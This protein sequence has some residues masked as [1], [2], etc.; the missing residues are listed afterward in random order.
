MVDVLGARGTWRALRSHLERTPRG[1]L[2]PPHPPVSRHQIS[3]DLQSTQYDSH[4]AS[5]VSRLRP[6]TGLVSIVCYVA[7]SFEATATGDQSA[8]KEDAMKT[9]LMTWVATAIGCPLAIVSV[10]W[11]LL[12][13]HYHRR[14][15]HSADFLLATIVIRTSSYIDRPRGVVASA[16]G[17]APRGPGIDSQL[18]SWVFLPK[19]E[20]SQRSPGLG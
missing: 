7:S 5:R 17:Y 1:G 20:L 18:A 14:Q 12:I 15:W 19:G 2:R 9:D 16:P 8:P 4:G 6:A 11:T 10:C 3:G 13:Y